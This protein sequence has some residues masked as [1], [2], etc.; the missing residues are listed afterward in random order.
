MKLLKKAVITFLILLLVLAGLAVK[1]YYD[2]GEFSYNGREK[3]IT[4]MIAPEYEIGSNL[5]L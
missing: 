1:T 5:D 4:C 3:K 2:A